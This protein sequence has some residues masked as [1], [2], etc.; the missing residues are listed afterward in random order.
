MSER[1]EE[2]IEAALDAL[3]KAR[4]PE[5]LEERVLAAVRVREEEGASRVTWGSAW[6]RGGVAAAL[7]VAVGMLVVGRH[8]VPA[9][10]RA[11]GGGVTHLEQAAV[12]DERRVAGLKNAPVGGVPTAALVSGVRGA[13]RSAV[14][15]RVAAHSNAELQSYPA[16][17]APLTE[18]ERLLLRI[19]HT[20]DPEE[21]AMLDPVVREARDTE[22]KAEVQRFFG[23]S[24]KGE[25]E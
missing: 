1:Q 24:T 5:G 17:A 3:R 8:E 12:G 10:R 19:A 7:A 4:T 13:R 23:V 6:A 20:G 25:N 18:E 15:R 2:R 16:P 11:A 14:A 9:A 22:E 21:L